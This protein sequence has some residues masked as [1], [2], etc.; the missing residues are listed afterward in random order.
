MPAVTWQPKIAVSLLD[1]EPGW[2]Q[3]IGSVFHSRGKS[4]MIGSLVD[5]CRMHD[6]YIV[7]VCLPSTKG[8]P[9]FELVGKKVL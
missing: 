3:S 2:V 5:Y 6:S 1:L 9:S 7:T 4:N 8:M